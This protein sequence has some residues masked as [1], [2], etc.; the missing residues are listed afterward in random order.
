VTKFSVVGLVFGV[1][2][3]FPTSSNLSATELRPSI[4][5]RPEGLRSDRLIFA[6]QNPTPE[7]ITLR[8]SIRILSNKNGNPKTIRLTHDPRVGVPESGGWASPK[9]WKV[10]GVVRIEP[11]SLATILVVSTG[12]PVNKQLILNIPISNEQA[13]SLGTLSTSFRLNARKI[14]RPVPQ[15]LDVTDCARVPPD[16]PI[17]RL[18]TSWIP[19]DQSPFNCNE[20]EPG[21]YF[22]GTGTGSSRDKMFA[23]GTAGYFVI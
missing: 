10:K 18:N 20:L 14:L 11:N 21:I 19:L 3:T 17:L 7:R 8:T 9:T 2:S 15:D 6:I 12:L 5:L 22:A 16:M 4:V 1:L 13:G 23:S